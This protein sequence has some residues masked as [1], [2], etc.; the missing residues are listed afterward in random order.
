MLSMLL[1][2]PGDN[3]PSLSMS[4]VEQQPDTAASQRS[5][6]GDRLPSDHAYEPPSSLTHVND[7]EALTA[8]VLTN[9][10]EAAGSVSFVQPLSQLS[11]LQ[12]PCAPE[13]ELDGLYALRQ[14]SGLSALRRSRSTLLGRGTLAKLNASKASGADDLSSFAAPL[15]P[16]RARDIQ[17]LSELF[18]RDDIST[19]EADVSQR[20]L[21]LLPEPCWEDD[22]FAFLEAFL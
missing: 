12:K 8:K 7:S 4:S 1:T 3:P 6:D 20:L 5:I 18:L 10:H 9:P 22:V 16:L 14:A 2:S 19:I 15:A 17:A 13:S 11:R 21:A